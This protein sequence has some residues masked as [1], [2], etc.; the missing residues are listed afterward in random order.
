MDI[1]TFL[2]VLVDKVEDGIY[3]V[4]KKRRIVSWNKAAENLTGYKSGEIVGCHCQ[5][6][7]LN[8]INKEGM[9]LCSSSC[10]LF[11]TMVDGKERSAE[12]MLRH[13]DGYRVPVMVRTLPAYE[14]GEIVGAIE[15]FSKRSALQYDS[16]FVEALTSRA[17]ND[18]LTNLPNR[19]FLENQLRYKLQESAWTDSQFCIA[20]AGLD[21]FRAFNEFYGRTSGDAALKSIAESFR[22]NVA[23]QEIIGRWSDDIFLGIFDYSEDDT[24]P[25]KIAENMRTLITHSGIMRTSKY[26]TVTASV[27]LVVA[28]QNDTM[29][30][31]VARADDMMYKSKRRGRN[32]STIHLPKKNNNISDSMF[33]KSIVVYKI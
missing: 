9:P 7:M 16:D 4:D 25:M 22:N 3:S 23:R 32:C 28:Q 27:G 17:V 5:D 30:T 31:L 29:E 20:L 10:P 14:N 12:V 11:E 1:N 6:N 15:M 21:N 33:H 24:D 8:H 26:L 18:S 13:K 2:D 19:S